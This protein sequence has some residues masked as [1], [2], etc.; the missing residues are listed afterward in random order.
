M[1]KRGSKPKN[2]TGQRFRKLVVLEMTYEQGKRGVRAKCHCDCGKDVIILASNLK[3]GNTSTCGC[4]ASRKTDYA[5]KKLQRI[6]RQTST[7]ISNRK[8]RDEN[9]GSIVGLRFGRLVV[10]D[11]AGRDLRGKDR[12]YR[13]ICDCGST[14]IVRSSSLMR[15]DTTSCGCK[16][17]EVAK[18]MRYKN[19]DSSPDSP[20]R[21]LYGIWACMKERCRNRNYRD[22]YRYGGRG[23]TVCDE[24]L[25]W[26]NFRDWSLAHGYRNDLTI[27]RKNNDLGYCP[28]NCH[29]IPLWMQQSNTRANLRIEF[30]GSTYTGRQFQRLT[31]IPYEFVRSKA[32]QHLSGEQI[33][34]LY[35]QHSGQSSN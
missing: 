23:I 22:Y 26:E 10:Q 7:R 34:L 35:E 15:G 11:S 27:D 8:R 3:S 5:E 17:K 16:A 32:H 1:G 6:Q 29:W 24:W 19:G 13:C 28:D 9:N 12:L 18:Q 14:C 33:V 2:L 31:G 20:Y 25:D 30:K 4:G 21:R